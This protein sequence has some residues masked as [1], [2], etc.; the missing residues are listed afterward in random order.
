MTVA[1]SSAIDNPDPDSRTG[2]PV[3]HGPNWVACIDCGRPF[4]SRREDGG[5]TSRRCL[6]CR[7]RRI[8]AAA[9]ARSV[10]D[11]DLRSVKRLLPQ[12]ASTQEVARELGV[13][14]RTLRHIEDRALRKWIGGMRREA[15]R[16]GERSG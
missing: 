1:M 9:A 2:C 10:T 11:D 12:R 13:P 7:R 3:A 14:L 16:A 5:R 15:R 4:V 8:I 6:G